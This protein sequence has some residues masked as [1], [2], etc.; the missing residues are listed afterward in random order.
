MKIR[1]AVI[2][3]HDDHPIEE[4][5]DDFSHNRV[6]SQ[7]VLHLLPD[8]MRKEIE[9]LRIEPLQQKCEGSYD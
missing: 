7:C 8:E 3:T 6:I 2:F 5:N 4:G 1:H 9:R